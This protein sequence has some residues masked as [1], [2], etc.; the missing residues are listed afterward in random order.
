MNIDVFFVPA[1]STK[2]SK[3]AGGL[4]DGAE[5]ALLH[6]SFGTLRDPSVCALNRRTHATR[7]PKY[8]N[9]YSNNFQN[10]DRSH[11]FHACATEKQQAKRRVQK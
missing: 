1:L 4:P 11:L 10:P 7:I 2:S 5:G 3:Q 9:S 6:G 8:C